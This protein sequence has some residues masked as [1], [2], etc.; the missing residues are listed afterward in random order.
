MLLGFRQSERVQLIWNPYDVLYFNHF[1]EKKINY[2]EY[3]RLMA[4]FISDAVYNQLWTCYHNCT[5]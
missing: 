3:F 2:Y 5:F 1:K 4:S